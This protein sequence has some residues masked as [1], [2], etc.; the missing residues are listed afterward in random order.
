MEG[1]LSLQQSPLRVVKEDGTQQFKI[2]PNNS[3]YYTNIFG[4]NAEA[5][6]GGIRLRVAPGDNTDGYKTFLQ[7]S[8]KDNTIGTTTHPV[9]TEIN[10]LSLIHI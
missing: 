5:G 8:F 3:D 9:T 6:N 1:Q 4:Y 2:N 10:W 7:A